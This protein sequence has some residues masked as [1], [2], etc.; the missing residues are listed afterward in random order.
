MEKSFQEYD[1]FFKRNALNYEQVINLMQLELR[2]SPFVFFGSAQMFQ[3]H[4]NIME[5]TVDFKI[6]G[7]IGI[8]TIKKT[9][10][11]RANSE[12]TPFYNYIHNKFMNKNIHK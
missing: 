12:I 5:D 8:E 9:L 10:V 2:I 7:L 1:S 6:N 3:E 4:L 11:M